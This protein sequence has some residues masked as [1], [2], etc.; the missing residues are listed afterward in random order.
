M[1]LGLALFPFNMCLTLMSCELALWAWVITECWACLTGS[2]VRWCCQHMLSHAKSS[3]PRVL[4]AS[5]YLPRLQYEVLGYIWIFTLGHKELL[6]YTQANLEVQFASQKILGS[7]TFS[8]KTIIIIWI[9]KNMNKTMNFW[10]LSPLLP[11]KISKLSEHEETCF[12]SVILKCM[13]I[14]TVHKMEE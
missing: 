1:H 14:G 3:C 13:Q 8:G 11:F 5:F 9:K 12:S 6:V 10:F 7:I 4:E 2:C